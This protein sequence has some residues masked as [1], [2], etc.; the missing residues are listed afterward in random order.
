MEKLAK[1]RNLTDAGKRHRANDE[2]AYGLSIFRNLQKKLNT[3]LQRIEKD[4]ARLKA[5]ATASRPQPDFSAKQEVERLLKI[6][7][8][9]K[10][11]RNQII[12]YLTKETKDPRQAKLQAAF[13]DEHPLILGP[14]WSQYQELLRMNTGADK[15]RGEAGY[16]LDEEEA[17]AKAELLAVNEEMWA[18][19]AAGDPKTLYEKGFIAKPASMYTHDETIEFIKEHGPDAWMQLKFEEMQYG[20]SQTGDRIDAEKLFQD[21]PPDESPPAA[22]VDIVSSQAA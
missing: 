9:D 20:G 21:A 5:E 1:D 15:L 3:T 19:V 16:K 2:M 8:T 12:D 6:A 17:A 18:L 14:V 7:D 22:V 4:R 11:R 13:K 10:S